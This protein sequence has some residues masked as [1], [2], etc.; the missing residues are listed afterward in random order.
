VKLWCLVVLSS[1]CLFD[2][3]TSTFPTGAVHQSELCSPTPAAAGCPPCS[4]PDGAFCG[5]QWYSTGRRCSS[6]A[7]C[8]GA[9]NSCQSNYCVLKD[10]D[11]DGLDDDF[12]NEVATLN[13]PKLMLAQ[14]ES[15][16]APHGV[17]Y[18]ARRHPLNPARMAITYTVLYNLDCGLLNGH[19]GDAETFAITVDLDAQPG[20]AATVGVEAWAHAGTTCGSTSSCDAASGTGACGDQSGANSPREIVI[21]SSREK[22]ASYL[23]MSTCS[24][25]CLDECGDGERIVGPLLNV[26]EPGHPMVTDLTAQGFV[27]AADGWNLQLLNFNPWGTVEFAGGGRTDKPLTDMLAPPGQ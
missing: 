27:K 1:G 23:S 20:A 5:D 6:D 24:D 17:I 15:C 19:V 10:A 8:G 3:G 12:E 22:H 2:S 18:H 16:G 26:G 11:G 4:T 13:F 9:V 7:Q 25:N 14:G 21:Y